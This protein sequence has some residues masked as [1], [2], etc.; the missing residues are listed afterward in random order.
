MRVTQAFR[1]ELAPNVEQRI[2]LAKH[3]GAARF[4]YHG[5]LSRSREA[6]EPGRRPRRSEAPQGVEPLEAGERPL[7][8]GGLP[9]RPPG[10]LPGPRAGLPELAR[11][12]SGQTPFQAEEIPG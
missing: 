6:L 1:F 12:A 3:V 5:G 8:G 2:A 7:V 10:G 4:A 11:G 9:V